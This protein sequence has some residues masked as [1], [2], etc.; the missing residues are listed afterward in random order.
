MS[1]LP[2]HQ[3]PVPGARVRLTIERP[4]HIWSFNFAPEDVDVVVAQLAELAL[5]EDVTLDVEDARAACR[6]LTAALGRVVRLRGIDS[7]PGGGG[8]RTARRDR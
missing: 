3:D 2:P 8:Q 4:P 6:K 7:N 5:D 1:H